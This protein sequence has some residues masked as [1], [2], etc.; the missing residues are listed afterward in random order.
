MCGVAVTIGNLD[1]LVLVLVLV[2]IIPIALTFEHYSTIASVPEERSEVA[3]KLG[4]V[5]RCGV[6]QGFR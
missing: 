6:S 2:A 1:L 5:H 3:S 4:F